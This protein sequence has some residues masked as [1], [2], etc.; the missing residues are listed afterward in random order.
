MVVAAPSDSQQAG[1]VLIAP[2]LARVLREW[3]RAR[4]SRL[5]CHPRAAALSPAPVAAIALAAA[6]SASCSGAAPGART[7]PSLPH[8]SPIGAF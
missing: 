6:H 8:S 2:L 7:T 5:V 1:V 3:K 4:E